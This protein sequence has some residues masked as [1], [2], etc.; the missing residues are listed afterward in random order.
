VQL[1]VVPGRRPAACCARRPSAWSTTGCC[2]SSGPTRPRAAVRAGTDLTGVA[3]VLVT[4]VHPDHFH[5]P[6]G[7]GAAGRSAPAR[8]P[9]RAAGGARGRRA[10]P[11][12][13]GDDGRRR[14]RA[15]PVRRGRLRGAGRPATHGGPE[16][17]ARSVPL[18]PGPDQTARACWWATDTGVLRPSGPSIWW[19]GAGVRRRAARPHQR[20][21]AGAPRP[22]RPG[23]SRSPSCAR[24]GAWSTPR[25]CTPSTSGHDNPPP[26]ELEAVLAGWG[27]DRAAGRRRGS[28]W[29]TA[30]SSPGGRAGRVLVLGGPRSGK[31]AWAERRLAAE[32][33]VT[34]VATAPPREATGSGP[35][36]CRPRPSSP[37]LVDHGRDGRRRRAAADGGPAAARRRPG[38]WLTRAVDEADAWSGPL[39][40]VDAACDELVAAWRTPASPSCS[41]PPRSGAGSCRPARR[42]GASA[43]CSAP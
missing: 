33:A 9:R 42:G 20:P 39:D 12:P 6:A 19:P 32:P 2:S 18:R 40:A 35:P 27:A 23:R 3:A 21:P 8:R 15:G 26:P 43:T 24:G 25:R 34:Y 37:G 30:R 1:R 16:A 11:R 5:W 28:A 13:D 17:G 38:L 7:C 36:A 10:P 31:S 4:H 22:R 14:A 41:S 29:A